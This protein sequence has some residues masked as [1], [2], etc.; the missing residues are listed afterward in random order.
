[1][2]GNQAIS[3]HLGGKK[4]T[5]VFMPANIGEPVTEKRIKCTDFEGFTPNG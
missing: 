4:T 2:T 1:M 3:K 5:C